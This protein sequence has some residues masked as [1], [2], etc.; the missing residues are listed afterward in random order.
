M[1]TQV[2]I[3]VE[4]NRLIAT[5]PAPRGIK[6]ETAFPGYATAL[7]PFPVEIITEAIDRYLAAEFADISLKYYPR[8]PELAKICRAVRTIHSAELDKIARAEKLEAER[9][10][11]AESEERAHKTPE[12]LARGKAIYENFIGLHAQAKREDIRSHTSP[13]RQAMRA[14]MGLPEDRPRDE[15]RDAYGMTD[16]AMAKVRNRPLPKGMVSL[17]YAMPGVPMPPEKP[18]P[19]EQEDV[20]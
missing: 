17:G 11:M 10:E 1:A 4:M 19:P 12:Q 6:Y 9:R 2:E 5:L 3:G 8:A 13:E 14:R 20:P 18:T 15:V 7:A 16:E